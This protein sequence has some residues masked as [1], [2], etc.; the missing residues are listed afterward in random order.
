MFV[1]NKY[2]FCNKKYIVSI[3]ADPFC[4]YADSED[5]AVEM[6]AAYLIAHGN[7]DW[8]FDAIEMDVMAASVSKSITDFIKDADLRYCPNNKIYLPKCKV[9]EVSL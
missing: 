5:E 9:E 3:G 6:I 4:V 7:S 2:N 1:L 8:Y